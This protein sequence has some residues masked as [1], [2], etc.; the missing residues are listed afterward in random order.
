MERKGGIGRSILKRVIKAYVLLSPAP[1]LAR[2]PNL[3]LRYMMSY[4]YIF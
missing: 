3:T 2:T 4:K 1:A